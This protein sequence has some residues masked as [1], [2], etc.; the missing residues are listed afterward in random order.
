MFS[1]SEGMF[2]TVM[3]L[4]TLRFI[5]D[6]LLQPPYQPPATF[7]YPSVQPPVSTPLFNPVGHLVTA[8]YRR[9]SWFMFYGVYSG[10]HREF[11]L[12]YKI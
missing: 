10:N 9:F 1:V 4:I 3:S 12:A 6:N 5:N 2:I 11:Y 7:S 8:F